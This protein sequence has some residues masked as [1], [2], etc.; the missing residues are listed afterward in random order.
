VPKR[1][2][3]ANLPEDAPPKSVAS[4]N[5][6]GDAGPKDVTTPHDCSKKSA[7]R[8]IAVAAAW[9]LGMSQ[10]GGMRARTVPHCAR[11]QSRR[12]RWRS[13]LPSLWS[14]AAHQISAI[15]QL[16]QNCQSPDVWPRALMET[17]R[18]TLPS[19]PR[20]CDLHR[21]SDCYRVERTVPGRDF[22][23]LWINAF[24]RRTE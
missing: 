13:C 20:L 3:S 10:H 8:A 1:F 23:S 19:L 6:S 14:V 11:S 4:R 5:I 16:L 21:R 9:W 18:F 17:S 12:S 22:H 7:P 2:L 15:R 24:S